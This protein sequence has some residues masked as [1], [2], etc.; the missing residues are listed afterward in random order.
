[1]DESSK[2]FKA[3]LDLS[4][5][6]NIR[7]KIAENAIFVWIKN[8]DI[9]FR[10]SLAQGLESGQRQIV[11]IV[12]VLIRFIVKEH[13]YEDF[14]DL[15]NQALNAVWNLD[16]SESENLAAVCCAEILVKDY[17]LG[18]KM[19]LR[20]LNT[21]NRNI[22]KALKVLSCFFERVRSMDTKDVALIIVFVFNACRIE[23]ASIL[24]LDCFDACLKFLDPEF[25]DEYIKLTYSFLQNENSEI[26]SKSLNTLLNFNDL[27]QNHA[28]T[29]N[30]L[31]LIQ[32]LN[33]DTSQNRFMATELLLQ[34]KTPLNNEIFE[35]ILQN[36]K[37]EDLWEISI[38]YLHESFKNPYVSAN[39]EKYLLET[40]YEPSYFL[41]ILSALS[42][43]YNY[44]LHIESVFYGFL[45]NQ[46]KNIIKK[47][48]Y[49]LYINQSFCKKIINYLSV[50]EFISVSL[51]NNSFSNKKK[52]L[53]LW[54]IFYLSER[55]FSLRQLNYLIEVIE[56]L[57]G[58]FEILSLKWLILSNLFSALTKSKITTSLNEK[59]L[60][61]LTKHSKT[62]EFP[63]ILNCLNDQLTQSSPA[64]NLSDSTL[65]QIISQVKS[66]P[67]S[68]EILQFFQI[69]ETYYPDQHQKHIVQIS[70]Y[71]NRQIKYE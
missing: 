20:V 48:L 56:N 16:D 13:S 12:L 31:I 19:V 67:T 35:L 30:F 36:L 1:M 52:L 28:H 58:D 24:C 53:A 40:I 66:H 26:R 70:L 60:P 37:T 9:G 63:L 64:L 33:H 27:K 62:Q 23:T 10:M 44:S 69:I 32:I 18:G 55:N 3:I 57:S 11:N 46:D 51:V 15:S 42:E 7:R 54:G 65:S 5:A 59:I 39:F 61:N 49:T 2:Y 68:Q 8:K 25:F 45:C 38:E 50:V 34:S 47:A 29:L 21:E 43:F 17:D 14:I 6:D 22:L 41:G 71:K 4:Q